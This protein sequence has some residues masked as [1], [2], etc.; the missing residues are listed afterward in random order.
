MYTG[1]RKMK[2][3]SPESPSRDASNGGIYMCLASLDGELFAKICF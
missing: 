3:I 2:H 1:H